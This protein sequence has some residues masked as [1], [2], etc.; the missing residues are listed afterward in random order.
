[1]KYSLKKIAKEF[2]IDYGTVWARANSK[3]AKERWGIEFDELPDGTKKPF[4]PREKVY[5]WVENKKNDFRRPS[6]EFLERIQNAPE[7]TV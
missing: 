1:M 2:D 4:V 5:L 7:Q 6:K 3:Y